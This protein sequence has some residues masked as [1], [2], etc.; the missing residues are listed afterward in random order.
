MPTKQ[1]LTGG[2][3]LSFSNH[4]Q[5]TAIA[6][7]TRQ[8]PTRCLAQR[9]LRN[10]SA[11]LMLLAAPAFGETIT[12]PPLATIDNSSFIT[13]SD[14]AQRYADGSIVV[15]PTSFAW[16]SGV[17]GAVELYGIRTTPATPWQ[18]PEEQSINSYPLN[19]DGT[20]N[21]GAFNPIYD[22]PSTT[23]FGDDYQAILGNPTT[24]NSLTTPPAQLNTPPTPFVQP[25]PIA[26][27]PEPGTVAL[28]GL[29][30]AMLG[31]WRRPRK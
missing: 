18:T 25:A 3:R 15:V 31:L 28:A 17:P 13:L 5:P 9:I 4:R 19:P 23:Y 2:N 16:T 29:G 11:A 10:C 30:L 14:A 24:T 8:L 20:V 26:D 6:S 12:L 1:L 7:P 21:F 27:I 22:M